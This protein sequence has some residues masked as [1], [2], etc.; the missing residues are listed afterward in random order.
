MTFGYPNRPMKTP[1]GEVPERDREGGGV[2]GSPFAG[3]GTGT[4]E[5]R[6]EAALPESRRTGRSTQGPGH[7]GS[8]TRR[9]GVP[10]SRER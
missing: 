9:R 8:Y 7:G 4:R 5:R 6:A 1:G 2:Q 10:E 3:K